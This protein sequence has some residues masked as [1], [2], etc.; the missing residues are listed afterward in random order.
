MHIVP[1]P[2][3]GGQVPASSPRSRKLRTPSLS[4]GEVMR[5]AAA[6]RHLKAVYGSWK[7]LSEVMGISADGLRAIARGAQRPGAR[8]AQ[9][10]AIAVGK[11]FDA[12]LGGIVS[13]DSCSHCGAS[14][15]G[16]S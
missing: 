6:L 12:L 10:A 2:P 14:R 1:R 7:G 5:L 9:R 11:P 13:A 16:A 8:V 3:E 15:D 4:D